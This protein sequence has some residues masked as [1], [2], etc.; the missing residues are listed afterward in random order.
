MC[1]D[2]TIKQRV[3]GFAICSILGVL[4]S[5]LAGVMVFFANFVAFGIFYSLGTFAALGSTAFLIGP[6]KQLK[7]M[8]EKTRIIATIIFLLSLVA[9]LVV[10]FVV[11][12]GALVI[13]CVV[14]QFLAFTWYSLSYIPFARDGIIAC[15]KNICK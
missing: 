7:K 15:C 11:Q 4:L 5:V 6:I 10:A 9:T 13:V 14:V 12:N 8:F 3:I 1:P 2:M